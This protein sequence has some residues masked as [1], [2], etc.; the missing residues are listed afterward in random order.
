MT[1]ANSN[2]HRERPRASSRDR[3]EHSKHPYRY[4]AIVHAGFASIIVLFAWLTGGGAVKAAAA[5][6]AYWLI[7][8]AYS[9]FQLR[10]RIAAAAAAG[11]EAPDE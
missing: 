1:D 8:T 3:I 2:G 9:W 11:S 10:R 5:A 6:A 4:A 7:A